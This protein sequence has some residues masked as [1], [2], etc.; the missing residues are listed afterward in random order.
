MVAHDWGGA[1]GWLFATFYASKVKRFVAIDI[2]HPT[3]FREALQRPQQMRSSWY[4]WL[5]QAAGRGR[6]ELSARTWKNL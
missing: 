1:I 6:A 4:I 2:P 5:F 3:A